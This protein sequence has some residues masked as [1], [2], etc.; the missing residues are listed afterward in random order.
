MPVWLELNERRGG[1]SM[2]GSER[3]VR[4]CNLGLCGLDEELG[5]YFKCDGKS[6]E[7]LYRAMT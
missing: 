6:L 4:E 1:S 3:W 2:V 5:F 7:G